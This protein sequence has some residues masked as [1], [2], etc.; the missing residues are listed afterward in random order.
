MKDFIKIPVMIISPN[1]RECFF[2]RLGHSIENFD[3]PAGVKILKVYDASDQLMEHIFDQVKCMN[4]DEGSNPHFDYEK[5]SMLEI[6]VES[7]EP[8]RYQ[9]LPWLDKQIK[10]VVREY[11]DPL[12]LYFF[13]LIDGGVKFHSPNIARVIQNEEFSFWEDDV[14]D[15]WDYLYEWSEFLDAFW[16]REKSVV[17]EFPDIVAKLLLL[18]DY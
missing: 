10:D 8:I 1:Y 15:N 16:Y 3:T 14:S 17:E 12:G 5:Y 13:Y 11:D 6:E 2:N 9:V 4:V 7:D 18:F